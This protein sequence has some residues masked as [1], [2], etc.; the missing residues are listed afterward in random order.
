MEKYNILNSTIA[1][2]C[3]STETL[4]Y[5]NHHDSK[6]IYLFNNFLTKKN[7]ENQST[8]AYNVTSDYCLTNQAKFEVEEV[9]IYQI[10][11]G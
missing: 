6:G 4:V 5:G 8:K 9:E 10:L 2:A 1:F 3:Y 11:F 7:E